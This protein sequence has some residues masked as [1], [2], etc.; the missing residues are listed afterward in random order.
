MPAWRDYGG[1]DGLRCREM[2]GS[3][4][5]GRFKSVRRGDEQFTASVDKF[6]GKPAGYGLKWRNSAAPPRLHHF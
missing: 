4:V 3:C 2:F 1:I 5:A 6:V